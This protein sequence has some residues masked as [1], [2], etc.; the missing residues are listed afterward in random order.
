VRAALQRVLLLVH[1]QPDSLATPQRYFRTHCSGC[2]QGCEFCDAELANDVGLD[3][4]RVIKPPVR[5]AEDDAAIA[6]ARRWALY[7]ATTGMAML[8]GLLEL[9]GASPLLP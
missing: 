3:D 2:D 7:A 8:A 1:G 6:K 4:Q 9:F 5:T